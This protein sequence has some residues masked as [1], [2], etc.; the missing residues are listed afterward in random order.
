M[1]P[2]SIVLIQRERKSRFHWLWNFHS[3][4]RRP[5]HFGVELKLCHY[6]PIRGTISFGGWVFSYGKRIRRCLNGPL[7]Q[8]REVGTVSCGWTFS[9]PEK[10]SLVVNARV[11][12]HSAPRSGQRH[13]L[14]PAG[15]LLLSSKNRRLPKNQN[16]SVWLV[17]SPSLKRKNRNLT[18]RGKY[19]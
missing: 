4:F 16:I 2:S 6:F 17:P 18:T 9:D 11:S 13:Q 1:Y 5:F 15:A 19:G 10:L 12:L 14:L 7:S 8:K 3:S